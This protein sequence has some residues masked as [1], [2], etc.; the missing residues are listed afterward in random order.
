MQTQFSPNFE[1]IK[2]V[3]CL[4]LIKIMVTQFS[5]DCEWM[6]ITGVDQATPDLRQ[7]HRFM[8]VDEFARRAALQPRRRMRV[9]APMVIKERL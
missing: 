3:L 2:T 1:G 7:D 8:K 5:P 6:A 4:L 9:F